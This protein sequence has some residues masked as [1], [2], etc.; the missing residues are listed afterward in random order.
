[1]GLVVRPREM[2]G[3]RKSAIADHSALNRQTVRNS[4][5]F[6]ESPRVVKWWYDIF[7]FF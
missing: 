5:P 6:Y 7:S 4:G 2:A 1:M 3:V